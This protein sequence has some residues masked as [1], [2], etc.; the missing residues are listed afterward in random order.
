M[1]LTIEQLQRMTM[2]ARG[3]SPQG[4]AD[5]QILSGGRAPIYGWLYDALGRSYRTLYRVIPTRVNGTG[6]VLTSNAPG[7]FRET[8]R[9]PRAFQARSLERTSEKAKITKM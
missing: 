6:P 9:Y 1:A 5:A 8:P 4:Q 3:P 2:A 7:S